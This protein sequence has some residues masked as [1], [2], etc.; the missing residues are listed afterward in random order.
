[1]QSQL[2]V[3]CMPCF[4][5]IARILTFRDKKYRIL[6]FRDKK[7][8]ILTFCDKT[9]LYLTVLQQNNVEA[10]LRCEA[11]LSFVPSLPNAQL[12]LMPACDIGSIQMEKCVVDQI[13]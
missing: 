6:T 13:Q 11:S 12:Q 5:L 2:A 7:Y 3:Q 9:E 4:R 10:C 1:M 8:R